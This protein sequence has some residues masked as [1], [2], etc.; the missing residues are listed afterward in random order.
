MIAK[1]INDENA[2]MD[3]HAVPPPEYQAGGDSKREDLCQQDFERVNKT[4]PILRVKTV[5]SRPKIDGE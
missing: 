5:H 4:T 2:D 3:Y 1:K